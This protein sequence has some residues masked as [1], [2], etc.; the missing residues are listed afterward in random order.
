MHY[1]GRGWKQET[2]ILAWLS[3][4][5]SLIPWKIWQGRSDVERKASCAGMFV[6]NNFRWV[7]LSVERR[8]KDQFGILTKVKTRHH[9][10]NMALVD[11]FCCEPPPKWWHVYETTPL[12][13]IG[14]RLCF[15][16]LEKAEFYYYR[17]RRENSLQEKILFVQKISSTT[18][19]IKREGRRGRRTRRHAFYYEKERST[20]P[21]KS[22]RL[23]NQETFWEGDLSFVG[24]DVL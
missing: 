2:L 7:W 17:E 14:C 6:Q 3:F 8:Y 13:T 22:R 24:S 16:K 9:L 10:P 20:F 21:K 23:H 19:S 1:C 12:K 15:T 4:W 5:K 11:H 18:M